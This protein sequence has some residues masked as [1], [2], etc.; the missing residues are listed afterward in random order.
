MSI[1]SYLKEGWA[2]LEA[3][4]VA[5]ERYRDIP[6]L[7][8]RSPGPPPRSADLPLSYPIAIGTGLCS[9]LAYFDKP[10]EVCQSVGGTATLF[11]LDNQQ[12]WLFT[13][14]NTAVISCRGTE[15]P[16]FSQE[17][18]LSVSYL[19][20]LAM[21]DALLRFQ[22]GITEACN[23]WKTNLFGAMDTRDVSGTFGHQ[24]IVHG[25]FFDAVQQILTNDATGAGGQS[26]NKAL[27]AFV[28]VHP[29]CRVFITGHSQGGGIGAILSAFAVTA[30]PGDAKNPTQPWHNHLES[31][32]LFAPPKVFDASLVN[33]LEHKAEEAKVCLYSFV[34]QQ[35]PIPHL[36]PNKVEDMPVAIQPAIRRLST[37][38]PD[39]LKFAYGPGKY[40]YLD[41][42][43][44]LMSNG[45][46]GQHNPR[47]Q[48]LAGFLFHFLNRHGMGG[49]RLHWFAHPSWLPGYLGTLYHVHGN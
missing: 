23:D 22:A 9:A 13:W 36:P 37:E 3:V 19:N 29:S 46:I 26:L 1:F 7:L 12:I 16:I 17:R 48:W 20:P 10:G 28:N 33:H 31:A 40:V 39:F 24:G 41:G 21:S 45:D 14:G 6:S 18:A 47:H 11:K 5:I 43:V 30:T 38:H 4:G 42:N 32:Y 15:I 8:E 34:N 49:L 25:R 35:D 2:P 27:N 44:H